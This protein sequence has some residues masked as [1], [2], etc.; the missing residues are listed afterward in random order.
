[1]EENEVLMQKEIEAQRRLPIEV[2][3]VIRKKSFNNMITA[4]TIMLY[5]LVTNILFIYLPQEI[6]LIIVKILA[7]ISAIA[8]VCAFEIGYRRKNDSLFLNGF[9]FLLFSVILLYLPYIYIYKDTIAKI[10]L[11][12]T[13]VFFAVYY[14][15]KC[16]VVY[17]RSNIKHKNSMSDIR[18]ILKPEVRS[19]INEE[20]QKTLKKRKEEAEKKEV[21]KEQTVVKEK[22][23]KEINDEKVAQMEK[24]LEKMKK[25]N[26]RTKQSQEKAK[27]ETTVENE[28]NKKSELKKAASDNTV[29]DNKKQTQKS[30]T[31]KKSAKSGNSKAT[32]NKTTAKKEDV[33][34]EDSTTKKVKKE[35]V[36]TKVETSKIETEEVKPKK[37]GRPKKVN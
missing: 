26:E 32:T 23:K 19:Y 11:M 28:K 37:R 18:D 9:E 20:S 29:T 15:I 5:F 13:S 1:M 22:T 3:Q 2:K 24:T 30:A 33:K 21:K 31:T 8:T 7:G 25:F 34:K 27:K 16:I 4:I 14:A 36:K 10:F 17:V 6:F 12:L 35:T